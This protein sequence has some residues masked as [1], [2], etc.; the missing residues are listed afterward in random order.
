MVGMIIHNTLEE[1]MEYKCVPAP[2]NLVIDQSGSHDQAVR[3][4]A[5]VINREATGGWKFHSMEQVSVT[6]EPPKL[7][8]LGGLLTLV[9]LAQQPSATTLQF[10]MLIF[11][12]E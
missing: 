11:S 10:N 5:D 1:N 4:F 6:Q 8:C 12:K 3:S 9:G 2:K 7:G